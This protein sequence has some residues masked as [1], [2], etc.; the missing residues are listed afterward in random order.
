MHASREPNI[1]RKMMSERKNSSVL[2]SI[3]TRRQVIAGVAVTIGALTGVSRAWEKNQEKMTEA[4][5]TGVEGLLT[6]LHQ[7]V[8][9]KASPQRIY[10]ALLDSKQFAEFTG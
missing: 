3:P 1:R 6:Y 4:Q 2:A 10:E 7:E 8:N 9:I 5:S